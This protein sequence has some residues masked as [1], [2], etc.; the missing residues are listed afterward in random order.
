MKFDR[1]SHFETKDEKSSQPFREPSVECTFIVILEI[2]PNVKELTNFTNQYLIMSNPQNHYR[3][4]KKIGVGGF[5][6]I[7][8]AEN[9]N[10]RKVAI[11]SIRKKNKKNLDYY[12]REAKIHYILSQSDEQLFVQIYDVMEDENYVHLV[13]EYLEGGDLLANLIDQ[14]KLGQLYSEIVLRN[15]VRSLLKAVRLL[16]SKNIVHR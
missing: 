5:S 10:G 12:Y 14:L 4:M 6:V 2:F 7:H 13:L 8:L 1:D 16:H 3:L 15:V 11:K 9:V